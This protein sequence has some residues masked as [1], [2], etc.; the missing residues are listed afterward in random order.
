MTKSTWPVVFWAGAA[1]GQFGAI[2]P[3][4]TYPWRPTAYLGVVLLV[5]LGLLAVRAG[6]DLTIGPAV[7]VAGYVAGALVVAHQLGTTAQV[8]SLSR[9]GSILLYG[10]ALVMAVWRRSTRTPA[11]GGP[12][13]IAQGIGPRRLKTLL[14]TLPND[15]IVVYRTQADTGEVRDPRVTLVV[16]D[17]HDPYAKEQVSAS[18]L[19][20]LVPD[21]GDRQVLLAGPRP[22]RK[23]VRGALAR[24]DVP[25][26]H[27]LKARQRA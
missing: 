24:L 20:R 12:L 15:A 27:V 2:H 21:I 7:K 22:F 26:E 16:G 6:S 9:T 4:W 1:V 25:K 18:G 10:T 8:T 23:Y 11:G 17:E 14:A 3:E 19:H 13:L 5:A